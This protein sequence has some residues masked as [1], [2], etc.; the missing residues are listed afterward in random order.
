MN[1]TVKELKRVNPSLD[2][3]EVT[4]E[5]CVIKKFQ[6]I[7]Q[8]Q[9]DMVWNQLN[10]KTKL[11]I[12]D[13]KI[14]RSLM[15]SAIFG[16]SV[17]F[18]AHTRRYR[19]A[20]YANNN[21]GWTL[22]NAADQ[23]FKL[24]KERVFN[25]YDEFDPEPPPKWKALSE[26]L[27]VEIPANIKKIIA[28]GKC[29]FDK[30][31]PI[32]ILVLC[33]DAKTCHQLNQYL[34][35]GSER[36]LFWTALKNDVTVQK[37]SSRYKKIHSGGSGNVN[38]AVTVNKVKLYP[39]KKVDKIEEK[40]VKIDLKL[41]DGK[42]KRKAQDDQQSEETAKEIDTEDLLAEEDESEG[43]ILI[44]LRLKLIQTYSILQIK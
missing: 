9:L 31:K 3:E 40:G 36:A 20:D 21:S 12:T 22:N 11:L 41:C 13:L 30:E 5:N 35:Q 44:I 15:F 23:I 42:R 28:D 25:S 10:A 17:S 14:L 27:R 33:H 4:V 7:L 32:R 43:K 18:Y 2:L 26:I 16:D 29:E 38:D 1:I 34:T 24:S 8:A 6:K 39:D 19:G 37:L